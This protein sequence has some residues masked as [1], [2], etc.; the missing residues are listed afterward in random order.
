MSEFMKNHS[1]VLTFIL[2][3]IS[4]GS[5]P[6]SGEEF[7]IIRTY[8][9]PYAPATVDKVA[10]V[11]CSPSIV[12]G[13]SIDGPEFEFRYNSLNEEWCRTVHACEKTLD[14]IAKRSCDA[15]R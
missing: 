5:L 3:S 4:I 10:V 15:A 13:V 8:T 14:A 6:A 12:G 2:A 11:R 9:D 1:L 7:K